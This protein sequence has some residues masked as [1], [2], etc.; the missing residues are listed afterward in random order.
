MTAQELIAQLATVPPSSP[1]VIVWE[2]FAQSSIQATEYEA[3]SGEFII[4]HDMTGDFKEIVGEFVAPRK[5]EADHGK[6]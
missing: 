5:D 3:E 2:D 6:E 4:Y 1:I